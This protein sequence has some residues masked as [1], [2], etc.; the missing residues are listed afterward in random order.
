MN[1]TDW[2]KSKR[3]LQEPCKYCISGET[4]QAI[5]SEIDTNVYLENGWVEVETLDEDIDRVQFS[6][7]INYCPMCGRKLEEPT[8]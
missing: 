2:G 6:A 4:G 5:I 1:P 7:K 3:E 8:C